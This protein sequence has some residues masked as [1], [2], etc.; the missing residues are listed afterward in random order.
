MPTV[1][2]CD[3]DN[4]FHKKMI[5]DLDS[6]IRQGFDWK[7]MNTILFRQIACEVDHS[8]WACSK[9]VRALEKVHIISK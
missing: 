1:F 8:I 2:C 9:A 7:D 4:R 3:I 6:H 5:A